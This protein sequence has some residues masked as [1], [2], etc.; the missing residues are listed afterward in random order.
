MTK[1]ILGFCAGAIVGGLFVTKHIQKEMEERLQEE[2]RSVKEVFARRKTDT[3]D[4]DIS[5]NEDVEEPV[6]DYEEKLEKTGYVNYSDYSKKFQDEDYEPQDK[7]HVIAP[8][9]FGMLDEYE[10]VSLLYFNDGVLTDEDLELVDDVEKTVGKHSLEHFGEYEEDSVFV[11]NDQLKCD[12]EILKD[13]RNYS[14][15]IK[16]IPHMRR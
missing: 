6:K 10:E 15:A 2:I 3:T 7:P 13:L 11:R 12:F 4:K 8:D 5:K 14:D 1:F 9:D 16:T